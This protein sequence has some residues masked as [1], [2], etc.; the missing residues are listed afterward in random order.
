MSE[1]EIFQLQWLSKCFFQFARKTR[2]N[3]FKNNICTSCI[4]YMP[5][6]S[7]YLSHHHHDSPFTIKASVFRSYYC[8]CRKSVP[9]S[10]CGILRTQVTSQ[11]VLK[12][13]MSFVYTVIQNMWMRVLLLLKPQA[14]SSRYF[15]ASSIFSFIFA[16]HFF[17]TLKI[18]RFD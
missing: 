2:E 12:R 8:I 5:V 10:Q 9:S 11:C 6:T 18:F 4:L 13:T 1:S 17:N 14:Q 16:F 15:C 7:I 3:I